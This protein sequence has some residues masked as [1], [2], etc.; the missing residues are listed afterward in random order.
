[1]VERV[2]ERA[3]R[4][5]ESTELGTRQCDLIDRD[6][7]GRRFPR[8]E[9]AVTHGA[10]W[11]CFPIQFRMTTETGGN[12]TRELAVDVAQRAADRFGPIAPNLPAG[13]TASA[14]RRTQIEQRTEG[15]RRPRPFV[16]NFRSIRRQSPKTT[17]RRSF[18]IVDLLGRADN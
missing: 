7:T 13:R 10:A 16:T 4:F 15:F 6:L 8:G 1:M 12:R 18:G 17:G 2:R 5:D 11:G 9:R 3:A 14:N